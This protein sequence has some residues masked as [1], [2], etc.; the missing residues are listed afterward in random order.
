MAKAAY[1]VTKTWADPRHDGEFHPNLHET[2]EVGDL[3]QVGAD[4]EWQFVGHGTY[5]GTQNYG[6]MDLATYIARPIR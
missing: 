2:F 3:I 4:I 5:Y 1:A 6:R